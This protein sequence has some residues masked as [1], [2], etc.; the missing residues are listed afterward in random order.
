MKR[1]VTLLNEKNHYLE[2]F[3]S[4]NESH[5]AKFIKGQLDDLENFYNSREKI[6]EIIR[7]IDSQIHTVQSAEDHLPLAVHIRESVKEALAIK[8]LYVAKILEQD[9][10]ILS[11]IESAKSE[12]IRELQDLRKFKKGVTGYKTPTFKQRVDEEV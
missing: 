7:Y 9:L 8:D 5:L 3:F 10:S 6:L 1:I 11:C 12:I 2:K 4:I